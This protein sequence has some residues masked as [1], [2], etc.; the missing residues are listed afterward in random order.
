MPSAGRRPARLSVRRP[1]D[2]L[3]FSVLV[4]AA[5]RLADAGNADAS[6]L[7]GEMFRTAQWGLGTEASASLAQMAARQARGDN[8][9][10]R[11]VRER[12]DLVNEWLAKDKQLIAAKS[13][14]P[15]KRKPEVEH[16]LTGRLT[17]IDTRLADI[18]RRCQRL[19]RLCR[20]AA[21]SRCLRGGGAGPAP[22]G[23]GA[24]AVPR[25]AAWQPTP[26]E[27]FMWVVTKT[28]MRW[29]R[30]DLGTPALPARCWRCAAA[31]MDAWEGDGAAKCA[32]Q[33]H[34]PAKPPGQATLPFDQ[35][36]PSSTRPCSV[37]SQDLIRD[38]HLLIVPSG[39][40]T[41]LP[42]QVLVTK[43]R[44]RYRLQ[45]RPRGSHAGMP[46]PCCP[47]SPR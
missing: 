40:L 3:A 45:V 8:A 34:C 25:H 29:V 26:E 15:T 42:F 10:A 22:R 31:S 1:A 7:A 24:R 32:R 28:D 17:A 21:P 18:D 19:P 38:K 30:S 9:L 37:R 13:E 5:H 41:Q 20:L 35:P 44:P 16:A 36:A 47:P 6:E 11:F 39:P 23:R 4:K 33:L 12:Q 46:L 27:T 14:P 2:D 43:P